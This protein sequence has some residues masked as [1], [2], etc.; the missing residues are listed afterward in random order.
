MSLEMDTNGQEKSL[1]TVIGEV[2]AIIKQMEVS[3]VPLETSF[4]LYQ[5]GIEKLKNCNEMLD[6]VEKKMLVI[7]ANGDLEDF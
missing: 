6:A 7:S 1:E 3:D 5:Q 4:Q 2:E